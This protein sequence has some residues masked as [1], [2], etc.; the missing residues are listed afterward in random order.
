MI[1]NMGLSYLKKIYTKIPSRQI[2][3]ILRNKALK[4]CLKSNLELY[5]VK[6]Y[7]SGWVLPVIF[8]FDIHGH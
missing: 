4:C 2:N 3:I 8:L 1:F 7:M 5:Y 6:N